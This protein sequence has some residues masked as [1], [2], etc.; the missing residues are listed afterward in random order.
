MSIDNIL[1]DTGDRF[2]E[3]MSLAV[4]INFSEVIDPEND[5]VPPLS[6]LEEWATLAY[7][8]ALKVRHLQ[9]ED[10]GQA[11]V[12]VDIPAPDYHTAALVCLRITDA[13]EIQALNYQFRDKNQ[14]TN[15]LT[16]PMQA[17]DGMI[18]DESDLMMLGD[19]ALCADVINN[20]VLVQHKTMTS[21]WAHMVVHGML[22]IM[23]YDHVEDEQALVMEQLE[24]D[25]L[26]KL[27][28]DNPYQ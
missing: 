9:T 15:V 19:I 18:F 26:Q 11:A 27:G 25:I 23:G 28:F 20:E 4:E 22:H 1:S 24:I 13:E 2:S 7:A 3:A 10:N 14:P 6:S 21:H 17:I 5:E 12:A 8:E 16:F